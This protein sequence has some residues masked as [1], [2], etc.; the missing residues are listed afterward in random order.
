MQ[1]KRGLNVMRNLNLAHILVIG[2]SWC[3]EV[4]IVVV[5]AHRCL[6][7]LTGGSRCLYLVGAYVFS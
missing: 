7:V 4:L 5:S 3:S 2:G 6:Q 1:Y